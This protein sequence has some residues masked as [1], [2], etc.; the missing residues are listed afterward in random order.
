M[1]KSLLQ[2]N[3]FHK[4]IGTPQNY[5]PH[6]LLEE[7]GGEAGIHLTGNQGNSVLS[8][9]SEVTVLKESGYS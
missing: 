3:K 6:K 9:S 2:G 4:K 8:T 5:P 7:L 1:D